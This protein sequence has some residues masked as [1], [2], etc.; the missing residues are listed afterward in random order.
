ML[1][2]GTSVIRKG[3]SYAD[4]DYLYYNASIINNSF[5]T[6][7]SADDPVCQYS[8]TRSVPLMTDASEYVVSV[9]NFKL[10]GVGKN[11]PV[12][13]PEIQATP[14]TNVNNTIYSVTFTSYCRV[15]TPPTDTTYVAQST[16]FIQWDSENKEPWTSVP[17]NNASPQPSTYYYCYSIEWFVKLLNNAIG[18]AWLDC[19]YAALTQGYL[20]GTKPPFFT[21]DP[22]TKKFH[23]FQD[24]ATCFGNTLNQVGAN[25][26]TTSLATLG[27]N[28]PANG[29]CHYS[30]FRSP[31]AH[32]SGE[33]CNGGEFSFVGMNSNLAQL[34]A[35]LPTKY[36]GSNASKYWPYALT[37][38]AMYTYLMNDSTGLRTTD[39]AYTSRQNNADI[40]YP[41]VVVVPVPNP[42]LTSSSSSII[43]STSA[44]SSA[45]I[46]FILPGLWLDATTSTSAPY[47]FPRIVSGGLITFATVFPTY[48]DITE[49]CSSIGSS[50]SPLESFVITTTHIP[51]RS[52]YSVSAIPY[53]TANVG[54]TS[55]S[56]ENF[57]RVLMETDANEFD[58]NTFRELVKYEPKT[59]TFSSLGHDHEGITELDLKLFWRHRLTNQLI[60]LTM[61][62]QSSA[63]IRLLFKRRDVP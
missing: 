25:L 33:Y 24:A 59:P 9:E 16:R 48:F 19:K 8:D 56:S 46:P 63:N 45:P 47:R 42:P 43:T 57:F 4:P 37:T 36:Y 54:T 52:E 41:E 21:Y 3:N 13:I 20:M 7:Q 2:L 55:S 61:P 26:T 12:L 53:G 34:I 58:T 40:Y 14:N 17:T 49:S 29:D 10:D 1:N 31:S 32:I 38:P 27:G 60:P 18:M 15:D 35:N 22:E 30:P 39:Q 5:V 23:L 28:T 6:S 44:S 51:V 50:W 62:N 11:L